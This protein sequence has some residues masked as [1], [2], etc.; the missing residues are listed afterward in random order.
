MQNE[1]ITSTF[2]IQNIDRINPH[3][4]GYRYYIHPQQNLDNINVS[5]RNEF[6]DFIDTLLDIPPHTLQ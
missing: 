6:I 1:D 5:M 2:V 4:T 3:N